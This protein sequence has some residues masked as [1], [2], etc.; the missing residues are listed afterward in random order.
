M[1]ATED[2]LGSAA[3]EAGRLMDA[4]REWLDARGVPETPIATD[5]AECRACPICLGLSAIREHHPEVVEQLGRAAE[6]MIAAVR[7]VVTD[8]EHSWA[9]NGPRDV[10]RIDIDS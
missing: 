9:D 2:P 10:E 5:S 8:H 3:Q 6:A 1:S 4:L 7:A